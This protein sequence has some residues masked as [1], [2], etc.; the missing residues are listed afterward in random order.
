MKTSSIITDLELALVHLLLQNT[1]VHLFLKQESTRNPCVLGGVQKSWNPGKEFRK[2]LWSWPLILWWEALNPQQLPMGSYTWA[3]KRW[4]TTPQNTGQ[5][6]WQTYPAYATSVPVTEMPFSA[7][8]H[9]EKH[10]SLMP[11][12]MRLHTADISSFPAGEITQLSITHSLALH[13]PDWTGCAN[14]CVNGSWCRGRQ[15]GAAAVPSNFIPEENRNKLRVLV[16]L[17]IPWEL[18]P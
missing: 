6:C 8:G 12:L 3:S 14:L 1:D 9:I 5:N 7:A 15:P 10:G 11:T 4:V 18:S 13:Q 17:Q 16:P 2:W